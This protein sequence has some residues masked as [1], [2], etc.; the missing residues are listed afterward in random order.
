M[1]ANTEK[2]PRTAHWSWADVRR[3][4]RFEYLP[5]AVSLPLIGAASVSPRLTLPQLIGLIGVAAA[6]HV[7]ISLENDIFDLPL[8]RTHPDRADYPLVKGSVQL[9]QALIVA[10]L[11]IPIAVALAAWLGGG[12]WAYAAIGLSAAMM[13]IYNAWGKRA[14]VPPVTDLI[15]GFGFAAI[16]LYGAAGI[17]R[18]T[19]LTAILFASVVT[20]MVLV[21]LL[22]GLRDLAND[23]HHGMRTTPIWFGARPMQSGQTHPRSMQV[24]AYGLL[25]ILIGLALLTLVFDEFGYA[26]AARVGVTIGVLALGAFALRLLAAFFAAAYDYPTMIS[27]GRLQMLAMSLMIV[28]LFVP[29]L[30][31]GPFVAIVVVFAWAISRL[32]ARPAIRFLRRGHVAD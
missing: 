12:S 18:P 1:A 5:F 13:T 16:C 21:N 25:A 30:E 14:P 4:L 27:V 2:R 32:D 22:G 24:Y 17:G 19:R 8:D 20:W 31:A 29:Y 11:Q 26:P 28:A 3:F 10:L 9:W 6:L 7:F 23:L 15:Q